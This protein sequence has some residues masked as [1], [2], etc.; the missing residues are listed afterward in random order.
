MMMSFFL[1]TGFAGSRGRGWVNALD[2]DLD[3]PVLGAPGR[4]GVTGERVQVRV[5]RRAEPVSTQA[6]GDQV[7]HDRRRP[8][9]RELPVGWILS[10]VDRLVVGVPFHGYRIAPV[11]VE[12]LRDLVEQR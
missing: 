12:Q 7:A 6:A 3:A 8:S 9:R 10:A 4:A 5:A 2:H 11:Q 1:V